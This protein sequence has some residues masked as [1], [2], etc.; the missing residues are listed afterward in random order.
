MLNEVARALS[1][2][3]FEREFYGDFVKAPEEELK[4]LGDLFRQHAA[5]SGER[6]NDNLCN[7]A[8]SLILDAMIAQQDCKAKANL[9]V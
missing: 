4:V 2:R 7:L 6:V 3:R 1:E 9:S 8:A 5:S